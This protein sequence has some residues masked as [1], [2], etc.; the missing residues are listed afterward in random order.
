MTA[1]LD[2]AISSEI[3]PDGSEWSDLTLS[4]GA[5]SQR[6]PPIPAAGQAPGDRISGPVHDP[7]V[8]LPRHPYRVGDMAELQHRRDRRRSPLRRARKL[9]SDVHDTELKRAVI[10]TSIYVV[11]AIGIVFVLAMC[12][13]ALLNRYRAGGNFFKLAL[14][15]P[16]L[17]PPVLA[18]MIWFFLVHFD[19]GIFN[20]IQRT[21]LRGEGINFLGRNPNALLT[22]VGVEVWRGLGF[23]VLFF[24]AGMQAVP[25]SCSMR[26]GWTAP[27]ASAGSEGSPLP[28]LRPLLLFADRHRHD[29]QLPAL[30]LGAGAH[31]GRPGSRDCHGRVVYLSAAC[32]PS[33]TQ[34]WLSPRRS[35]SLW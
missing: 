9:E 28:T 11:I 34:V 35:G 8:R 15:F 22:I 27:V 26:P 13:A 17:A 16:L 2:P 6:C 12:L 30:R 24:L 32:S 19:F 25:G 20:L 18:A 4:A 29:L 23:W 1:S 10:N 31:P 7:L 14:Y 21:I 3:A 33:R 5:V